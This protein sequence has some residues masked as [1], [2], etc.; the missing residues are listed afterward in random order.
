MKTRDLTRA[1]DRLARARKMLRAVNVTVSHTAEDETGEGVA[2]IVSDVLHT[3]D[4][5]SMHLDMAR[6]DV[7]AE[8]DARAERLRAAMQSAVTY[9]AHGRTDE[10]GQHLAC[11]LLAD[12]GAPV[13][14]GSLDH[15]QTPSGGVE[16]G[17]DE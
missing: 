12:E 10:A 17:I 7:T 9:L 8:D 14:A 13:L 2:F 15:A 3:L 5:A 6:K 16:D 4:A 11:T 1:Q